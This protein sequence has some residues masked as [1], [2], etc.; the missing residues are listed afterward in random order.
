MDK[1]IKIINEIDLTKIEGD[2]L[3]LTDEAD[4]EISKLLEAEEMVENIK[5]KL[6]ERFIEVAKQNPKLKR[7]EGEKVMVGYKSKRTK[8]ITG[9]PDTKF[10]E[11]KRNP[12]TSA[13]NAYFEATGELPIGIGEKTFE[14]ITFSKI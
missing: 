6:K 1:L 8:V 3:V 13:I 10:I 9:D 11:V 2:S 5:T 12:N 4:N 14:Y 7:Y